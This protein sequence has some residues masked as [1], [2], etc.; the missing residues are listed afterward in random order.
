M[1]NS[2]MAW[3]IP[4]GKLKKELWESGKFEDHGEE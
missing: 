1:E 4:A 2:G 3:K